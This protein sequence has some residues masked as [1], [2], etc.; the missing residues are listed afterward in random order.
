MST[1]IHDLGYRSYDGE[2]AGVA[3]A[4]GGGMSDY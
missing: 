2:R 1:Q 3:W 4:G